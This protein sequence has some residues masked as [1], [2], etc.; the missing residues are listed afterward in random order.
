MDIFCPCFLGHCFHG[1]A[2][3]LSIFINTLCHFI[4]CLGNCLGSLGI[5]GLIYA[6]D[7]HNTAGWQLLPYATNFLLARAAHTGAKLSIL[8]RNDECCWNL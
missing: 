5:L 8:G 4:S 7:V 3:V 1:Q 2:L 6:P